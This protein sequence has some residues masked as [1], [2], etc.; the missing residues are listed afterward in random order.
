MLFKNWNIAGRTVV[1]VHTKDLDAAVA[2]EFK[3]HLLQALENDPNAIVILD[4]TRVR[5]LDSTCLGALLAAYRQTGSVR[6]L[7]VTGLQP[8]VAHVLEVARVSRVMAV[9]RTV[10][11][12]LARPAD[13]W[14]D[15]A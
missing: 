13:P 7:A 4:L 14:L 1:E 12:A 6:K 10:D 3:N 11:E 9:A 8:P 5:F 15:K 2:T